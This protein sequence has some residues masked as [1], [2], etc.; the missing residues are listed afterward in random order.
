MH[1]AHHQGIN[2]LNPGGPFTGVNTESGGQICSH[3]WLLRD[4]FTHAMC[5]QPTACDSAS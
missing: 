4:H 5:V 3:H 1:M 2:E